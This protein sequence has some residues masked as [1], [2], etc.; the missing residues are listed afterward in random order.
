MFIMLIVTALTPTADATQTIRFEMEEERPNGYLVGLLIKHLPDAI[1]TGPGQLTFRTIQDGHAHL[2]TLGPT[3]GRIQVAHRIDREELCP[4][5]NEPRDTLQI[6]PECLLTFSVNLLRL[7]TVGTDIVDILRIII[8]LHDIDD[9][10]CFFTPSH[11][12]LIKIP[13]NMPPNMLSNIPLHA[14]CDLDT[15][16]G[17]GIEQSFIRLIFPTTFTSTTS[18][19]SSP[20]SFASMSSLSGALSEKPPFVL[21]MN[22]T[23]LITKPFALF[24]VPQQM[25]DYEQTSHYELLVEASGANRSE[26]RSCRLKIT[27]QIVDQNDFA[28]RFIQ[29]HSVIKIPETASLN[30]PI[31]T[32]SA[33]DSDLGPLYSQLIYEFDVHAT[34]AVKARFRIDHRNGSIFLLAPLDYRK[35]AFYDIPLVVRNPLPQENTESPSRLSEILQTAN[36]ARFMDRALLQVQV[37]DV[38]DQPPMISV[39]TPDG[40]D[41]ISL[42]EH[43]K[44]IPL[45]IAV[46]TVVDE[47]T[48]TGNAINCSLD[49]SVLGQFRLTPISPVGKQQS[50][51]NK[52]RDDTPLEVIYK[53]SA[54]AS[55]DR[56]VTSYVDVKIRCQDEGSPPLRAEHIVHVRVDDINDHPPVLNQT[57]LRLTVTEDSDPSRKH[58]GYAVGRI[59]ATDPDIGVNSRLTY[60]LVSRDD[61]ADYFVVDNETGMIRSRGN[62]DRERQNHFQLEIKVTDGGTPKL[63]TF[64]IV[65]V[66]ILDYNDEAPIF[67]KQAYEFRITENNG[68][69][70]LVGNLRASDKDEGTNAIIHFHMEPL[71]KIGDRYRHTSLTSSAYFEEAAKLPFDLVSYYDTVHGTYEIRIYARQ[72]LDR[73]TVNPSDDETSDPLLMRYDHKVGMSNTNVN[74]GLKANPS[75]KFWVVGEDAGTP[76]RRGQSLVQVFIDDM[77]DELPR[78]LSPDTNDSLISISYLEKTGHMIRQVSH[79]Y[80]RGFILPNDSNFKICWFS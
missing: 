25:F 23:G 31:Y 47:D 75:Y 65:D 6:K 56:E 52:K 62:L 16:P 69:G 35:Q 14:P 73:E 5:S 67:E 61:N 76:K 19:F 26:Q 15:G 9:N 2:F 70:E 38:N 72:A 57:K 64:G 58:I 74:N 50:F 12:Q 28:P 41:S 11:Q 8:L 49:D 7:N 39:F 17:N 77:N 66:Q 51:H 20:N 27:V 43:T 22:R 78:F 42:R 54:L 33:V 10:V 71:T 36:E 68:L 60:E 34:P 40:G 48:D 44:D 18:A 59:V 79:T 80:I 46:V 45:D 30:V 3:D 37:L 24:L 63:T 32:L 1:L 55:F 21:N 13:E 4:D 29:N 53:L